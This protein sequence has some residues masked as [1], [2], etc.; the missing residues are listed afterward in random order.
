MKLDVLRMA[1]AMKANISG[2]KMLH[3]VFEQPIDKDSFFLKHKLACGE[4]IK[5]L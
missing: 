1:S 2:F 4:V 3:F 5:T